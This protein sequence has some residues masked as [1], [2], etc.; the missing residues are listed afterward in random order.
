MRK[1]AI[2][3]GPPVIDQPFR[4]YR[5]M[6]RAE[7]EAVLRVVRSDCLSGFYGSWGP[8]FLGGPEVRAF[9]SDWSKKFK[10]K[11]SI[12]MNSA[13]SGLFAAVGAVGVGPGDE[14]IVPPYTMSATVM[15]P[16]IY[17]AVPVFA[18]I[19]S[20]TFCLDVKAVEKL[21]TPKTKAII[22]VNLFGHPARLHEIMKLA[23][24]KGI[25]VIE[26]NAQGPL[27]TENGVYAGTIADIGVFSLNY[28]KHIHTGEGGVCCTN[29]D[30]LALR[31]QMIRNHAENIVEHVAIKDITNMV[32]YNYR[33]T[34]LSAAVGREQLKRAEEYVGIRQELAE[35]LSRALG[36]LP[37]ITVPTVRA[38]CRHVFYVW[39]IKFNEKVVGVSRTAFS[40]ALAAEGFPH[41]AGYV[42]PLYMLPIFQKKIAIG[43]GGFPFNSSS[44]NYER[45][46]CPVA[47]DMHEKQMLF[48]SPCAFDIDARD[49]ERLI[50]AFKKVYE[51]R[52]EIKGQE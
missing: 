41:H 20:E 49:R 42:R 24:S 9:E 29:D 8:E 19:E 44:V 43:S 15:A 25:K 47:E 6:G 23:K 1:L 35:E 11:H 48:F 34:E 16:L 28:H 36:D 51:H 37:G 7:E 40:R 21:I 39:A 33:M 12:T 13:S 26:D 38:G 17:G 3:G 5:S 27:A 32:G 4:P 46:L 22:V 52:F 31:L 30:D 10:V 45:G 2:N 18:D 14:V 50:E